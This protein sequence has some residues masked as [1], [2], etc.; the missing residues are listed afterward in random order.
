M[1]KLFRRIRA[2]LLG[3]GDL[4]R[5]LLYA[6]GEILLN[7]LK[8]RLPYH[9]SLAFHFIITMDYN[10]ES[11]ISS[12]YETLKSTGVNVISNKNLQNKIAFYF[13]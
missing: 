5:Y 3:E 6:V 10:G 11:L 2:K 13:N 8:H 7:H 9:D 1:L 12:G 4:R